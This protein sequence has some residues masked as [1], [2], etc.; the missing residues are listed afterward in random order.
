MM[1]RG[2]DGS[3][4]GFAA[5]QALAVLSCALALLVAHPTAVRAEAVA[6]TPV[7]A[8]PAGGE[9]AVLTT[10]KQIH[11]KLPSTTKVAPSRFLSSA[12]RLHVLATMEILHRMLL[13]ELRPSERPQGIVGVDFSFA[14]LCVFERP[15]EIS[16]YFAALFPGDVSV[17]GAFVRVHSQL[18]PP[19][20]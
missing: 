16:H 18:A 5:P 17:E 19:A 12:H 9:A 2:R 1:R 8:S 7:L 3:R 13:S 4:K 20:A 14:A 11:S 6:T 15:V 10:Q